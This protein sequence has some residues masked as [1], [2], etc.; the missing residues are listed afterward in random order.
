M[1]GRM[2]ARRAIARLTGVLATLAACVTGGASVTGTPTAVS[3][4]PAPTPQA[5]TPAAPEADYLVF[6]AAEAV[7]QI[8]LVRFGPGGARIE[9][10]A[11]I[12]LNP[13][14]PV[15]PHGI[16]VAPG[17][18]HYYVSTAHGF[19]NGKLWKFTAAGDSLKGSVTLG[20]FPATLE[21]SP[22]GAFAY[23]VNF[24]LH[25]DMVPS[26]VSVVYVDNMVEIARIPTCTMP[27]G[28]RFSADGRKHYSTCM[29][30]DVLIEID[31]RTLDV[32]RHF[33]LAK[34]TEHGMAGPPAQ[35]AG[36]PGG[37]AESGAT[38]SP[39]WVQPALQGGALFV[40]C[41]KSSDI[42]ELDAQTW[43][44]RRR[45][46]AGDGIYNLALTSDDQILVGTN[47]RG[48]SVSIFD[49]GSGR[50]LARL[51]TR[52]RIPSGVAIS[53][54][55]RYAFVTVEGIGSEPG[56]LEI[57]DLRA[58][59]TVAMVDLGQMAGGVDVWKVIAPR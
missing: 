18:E 54:D 52:R 37:A 22:D 19:P 25:G 42:V 13:T 9:R 45:I 55:N 41:N 46:P 16:A 20:A 10:E 51:P 47:K 27:H 5:V 53:P 50:E 23:V 56:T 36:M 43:R 49:A 3:P 33:M 4:N 12:G 6:V 26:S 28:S 57:I 30:D 58:L 24:N 32:A 17:G 35:H 7:D 1:T 15:G 44:V 14:E 39:T 40:A 2:E 31:T 38:C 29:M 48:Q 59:R 11:R 21:L 8:A 34:G